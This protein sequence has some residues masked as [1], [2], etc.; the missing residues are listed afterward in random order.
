MI[1]RVTTV[2]VVAASGVREAGLA[3]PGGTCCCWSIVAWLARTVR[4]SARRASISCVM[5][6][7]CSWVSSHNASKRSVRESNGSSRS[8]VGL[9]GATSEGCCGGGGGG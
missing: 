9:E 3:G 4:K 6:T 8:G 1:E 7:R 5:R 2:V